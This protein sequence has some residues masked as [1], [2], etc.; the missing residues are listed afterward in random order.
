MKQVSGNRISGK[1]GGS[2]FGR[3]A[4]FIILAAA[5]NAFSAMVPQDYDGDGKTDLAVM[6][7]NPD[8]S[9]TTY[10]LRSRDGFKAITS[11]RYLETFGDF[12]G[13]GKTD[14]FSINDRSSSDQ[15]FW[16]ITGS[17]DNSTTT[18]QWGLTND[19]YLMP[20]DYDGDGKTDLAVYRD[21]GWWYI[22]NSS[23]G[24]L[25]AEKFG[26]GAGAGTSEISDEPF[27]GGDYD[28]DG[29]ADLAILRRERMFPPGSPI[30]MTMYIRLSRDGTWAA[31]DLGNSQ[32][33][34]VL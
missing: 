12:D 13:D 14:L 1:T 25:S 2:I 16:T 30:P 4:L 27:A 20:Q 3:F 18:V 5:G 29:K 10:I 19:D 33:T 11:P 9:I 31:Y 28:G 22:R 23:N 34:G 24:Q 21:G 15:L 26:R 8:Q 6:R 32:S 7:V 17:R